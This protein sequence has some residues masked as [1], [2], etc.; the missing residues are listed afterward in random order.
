MI[1]VL[2]SSKTIIKKD[3]GFRLSGTEPRFLAEAQT[4]STELLKLRVEELKKLMH[5]SENLAKE[6]EAK[7]KAWGDLKTEAWPAWLYFSGDVYRGLMAESLDKEDFEWAQN[8]IWTLSGLYGI[9]R[10]LDLIKPYRLEA[11][12]KLKVG[13]KNNLYEFWGN[14]IAREIEKNN[15]DEVVINLSSEE[16]IKLIRK[17]YEGRIVTPLFLQD[18]VSGVKFEAVHAKVARGMMARWIVKNRID[19]PIKL[20]EFAEDGYIFDELRSTELE[21]VFVRKA[22]GVMK[23]KKV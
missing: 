20:R 2:V 14:K 3:M 1:T 22:E 10:P 15:N 23:I 5:I 7:I 16:Y 12:F 13:G 21:P 4:L 9:A 8:K 19:D 11:A 6:V 18:R 17:F